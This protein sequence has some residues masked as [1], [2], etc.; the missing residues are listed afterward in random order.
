MFK[1]AVSKAAQCERFA[2]I[3]VVQ[4]VD[5]SKPS[6]SESAQMLL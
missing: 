5:T 6:A 2:D 1:R 4:I 3:V